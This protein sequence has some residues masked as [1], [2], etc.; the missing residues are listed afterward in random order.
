MKCKERA[1][2]HSVRVKISNK[3]ETKFRNHICYQKRSNEEL[4]C[5][6]NSHVNHSGLPA[7][8]LLTHVSAV[9]KVRVIQSTP[10]INVI[11]DALREMRSEPWNTTKPYLCL[12]RVSL[13]FMGLEVFLIIRVIILLLEEDTF[14]NL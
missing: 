4:P 13:I 1:A 9:A 2:S 11:C 3:G 5:K 6:Q 10:E 14:H 8:F 12:K 7:T